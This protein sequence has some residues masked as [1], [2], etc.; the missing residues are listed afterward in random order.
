[1]S[2]S[3]KFRNPI[4][5]LF[6]SGRVNRHQVHKDRRKDTKIKHKKPLGDE[7]E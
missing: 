4:T 2:D 7:D 5:R 1:M 6:A 3:K